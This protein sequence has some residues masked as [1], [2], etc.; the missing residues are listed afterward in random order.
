MPAG[1][2]G[3]LQ[4]LTERQLTELL[5]SPVC[6]GLG[7]TLVLDVLDERLNPRAGEMTA[8]RFL[9]GFAATEPFVERLRLFRTRWD[10]VRWAQQHLP[11][12]DLVTPPRREQR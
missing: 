3:L 5:K 8:M 11:D 4:R 10:F 7:K 12:L 6:F 1:P 2:R 9:A